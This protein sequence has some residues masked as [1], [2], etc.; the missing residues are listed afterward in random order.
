MG[1]GW[2][3]I[4]RGREAEQHAAAAP[5]QA[6]AIASTEQWQRRGAQTDQHRHDLRRRRKP[7]KL[8]RLHAWPGAHTLREGMAEETLRSGEVG[9]AAKQPLR[10]WVQPQSQNREE[11]ASPHGSAAGLQNER[12]E[13]LAGGTP[14]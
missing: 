8:R 1:W 10:R 14:V 2:C 12:A 11:R 5:L 7:L 9:C 13:L 6:R 3:S 4:G